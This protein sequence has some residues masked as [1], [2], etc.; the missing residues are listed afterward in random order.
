MED[1]LIDK[2]H[3]E[4]HHQ[5]ISS[6][7]LTNVGSSRGLTRSHD[8]PHEYN[9]AAALVDLVIM[10]LLSSSKFPVIS[11]S[12]IHS[13]CLNGKKYIYVDN[14]GSSLQKFPSLFIV[15]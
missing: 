10:F 13:F 11:S 2:K 5:E 8:L 9:K 3:G 12:L 4:K 7:H 1:P 14:P 15:P 6:A